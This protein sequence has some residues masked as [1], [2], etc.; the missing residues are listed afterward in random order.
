MT[1]KRA[2]DSS[3]QCHWC[4]KVKWAKGDHSA[5]IWG[6]ERRKKISGYALGLCP[7]CQRMKESLAL[8]MGHPI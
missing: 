7:V 8:G 1:N 3:V 5:A 2:S 6:T 4:R